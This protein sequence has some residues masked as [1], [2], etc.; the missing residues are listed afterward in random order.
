MKDSITQFFISQYQIWCE[1]SS[2]K[3]S[4]Y[5][6]SVFVSNKFGLKLE[7]QKVKKYPNMVMLDPIQ[8]S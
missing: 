2:H 7:G 1:D 3:Q 6:G 8:P 5:W 4:C